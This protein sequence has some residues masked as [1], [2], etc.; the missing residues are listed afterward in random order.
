VIDL[1][2]EGGD[3]GGRLVAEGTPEQ[4]VKTAG[5][6]TGEVLRPLLASEIEPAAPSRR[7]R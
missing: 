7:R 1:G 2:P 4:V 3:K 5:S 6:Y